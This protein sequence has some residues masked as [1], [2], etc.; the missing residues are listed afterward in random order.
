MNTLMNTGISCVIL[1]HFHSIQIILSPITS[2]LS[3]VKMYSVQPLCLRPERLYVT[4]T[5]P[6]RIWIWLTYVIYAYTVYNIQ[7]N[8]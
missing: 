3:S 4:R 6:N 2:L 1:G 7:K 8:V 5:S